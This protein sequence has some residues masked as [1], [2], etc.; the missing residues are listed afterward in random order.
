ML[1]TKN[2]DQLRNPTLGNRLWATFIFS[3]LC[4]DHM[5]EVLLNDYLI[6][7]FY[8]FIK[9]LLYLINTLYFNF[10]NISFI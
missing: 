9:V 6:L 8:S 3:A 7:L 4:E 10:S 1:T 5:D 2:Q